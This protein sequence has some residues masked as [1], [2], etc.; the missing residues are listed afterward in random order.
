MQP[1][2]P[3]R[4]QYFQGALDVLLGVV[5]AAEQDIDRSAGQSIYNL[6]PGAF[7]MAGVRSITGPVTRSENIVLKYLKQSLSGLALPVAFLRTRR[8][9]IRIHCC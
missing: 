4:E 7:D 5:I 6:I 8:A 3:H 1:L 2:Q 9:R